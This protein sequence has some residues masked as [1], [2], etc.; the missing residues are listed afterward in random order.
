MS[1][2]RI[3]L[4]K[5]QNNFHKKETSSILPSTSASIQ[6]NLNETKVIDLSKEENKPIDQIFELYVRKDDET[7]DIE[8]VP[9]DE[10]LNKDEKKA[11]KLV[12]KELEK[13]LV[14]KREEWEQREA[15]IRELQSQQNGG[16]YDPTNSELS[17]EEIRK[18]SAFR[19][20]MKKSDNRQSESSSSEDVEHRNHDQNSSYFGPRSTV[21][22]LPH[23]RRI[24]KYK[25]VRDKVNKQKI[26]KLAPLQRESN[27]SN[28]DSDINI[29]QHPI[30]LGQ[31]ILPPIPSTFRQDEESLSAVGELSDS[32]SERK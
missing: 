23:P 26:N 32:D 24:S 20:K 16:G 9:Y 5:I 8:T 3:Q 31:F 19:H 21:H 25:N 18:T 17:C 12:L 15:K 6:E 28:D 30:G 7:V 4:T 1:I 14:F 13:V 27:E 22:I 10:P 11:T 29:P 2:C